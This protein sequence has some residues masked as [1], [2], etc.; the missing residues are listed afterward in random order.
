VR[1]GEGG[2]RRVVCEGEK[3]VGVEWEWWGVGGR[4]EGGG[5]IGAGGSDCGGGSA[6]G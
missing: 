6:G 1:G 4:G 5:G 3:R 2:E